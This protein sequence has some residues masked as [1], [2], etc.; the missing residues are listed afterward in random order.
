VLQRE[1]FAD[2]EGAA[3][4]SRN[5]ADLG[6]HDPVM[7]WME[8]WQLA[9]TSILEIGCSNGWRVMNLIDRYHCKVKGIDP[10][11]PKLSEESGFNNLRHGHAAALYHYGIAEFDLVIYAFCLYLCDP[12]DYT[13][14]VKE[15][16]R[17][18][19]DGGHI[20]IHDFFTMEHEAW[21]TPYKHREGIFSHHFPFE[22]LWTANPLY[23]EIDRTAKLS[24]DDHVVVL[25]K[26]YAE[27]FNIFTPYPIGAP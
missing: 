19:A 25:R 2:G 20:I 13:A 10:V 5:Q 18:L 7:E 14:I 21:R 4:L 15:G 22:R 9:P 23:K 12:Q 27:A 24:H 8:R 6:K 3:W 16:D 26:S 1:A 11:V 17:V